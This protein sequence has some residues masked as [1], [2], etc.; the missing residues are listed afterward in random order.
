MKFRKK[1]N[2]IHSEAMKMTE[3]A[4]DSRISYL[5][6]EVAGLKEIIVRHIN[7]KEQT[8]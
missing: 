6:K 8:K 5:E 7:E 4:T 2:T 3:M 1:N